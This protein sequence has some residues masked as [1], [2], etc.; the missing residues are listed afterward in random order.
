MTVNDGHGGT[1]MQTVTVT[2]TGTNEP[3]VITSSA[4]AGAVTELA[5][6]SGSAASDSA[7]GAVTFTDLDLTDHHTAGFVAQAGGYLGAFSVDPPA[8]DSTGGGTGSVAWHFNVTDSALDSLAA[9][10]TLTQKYDVTVDDGHGGTAMQTVTVTITGT[11]D[12]PVITSSA[13]A[14]A[15]TELANTSGSAAS[16]SAQGAVTFTDLDLTDHHTAGFVAQAGGYLGAFSV[17]PPAPDSTGGGTGSVAW[18]FN[19]TDSALNSLAAGQTLTQK[20]DVTVDDGHGGTAMQTVTVTITGTNDPPVITSSAQAGAVTECANTSGS[21]ASDSAQ[22]AVTFTDLDLTDHHTA[23]FVAQ[24]GGYLGAFSVDPP[25]PDST[26][27]GTGSVAWHFNVTDSALD[28]L[29]A[30]QTL[31]QKYDVTVDDGHGGTAMQTVTVTITG[32][33][34]APTAPTDTNGAANSVAAHSAIGTSVGIAAHSTDPDTGDTIASY[35]FS[36][37]PGSLFAISAGGVI[38]VNADLS[39]GSYGVD[40]QALDNHGLAGASSHFTINVTAPANQAP[41]AANDIWVLSDTSIATGTITPLWFT[42]NDSDP[43]GNP[44]FITAVGG[45]GASGLTANFT[46][47]HLTS[48][49]GT[50]VTGIYTLTYTLSDGTLTDTNNT[51]SLTVVNTT[52][53]PDNIALDGNDFSYID[54]QSGTDTATG[55]TTLVGNAGIDTF[56]GGPGNDNLSGGAGADTLTGDNGRDTFIYAATGD[57]DTLGV[58]HDPRLHA[59]D[60]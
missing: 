3:P 9:G 32:T 33:N 13:Q 18:H 53:N 51:V 7:Q 58:R 30:G 15:V 25:A 37:N 50:A 44:L 36:S 43:D 27:G 19:V 57:F 5:N 31:T 38:T 12:P 47:G 23:G 22:G 39:A 52:S 29:A 20:Y 41:V 11:N 49:T 35:Q 8:P 24:A 2:I 10:Q 56:I 46:G 1:A 48:I 60:G 34:D 59:G 6:T 14:G 40:V 28:S 16:D 45:F 42:N 17:D 21:A 26:G 54:L 55:D 4:Q